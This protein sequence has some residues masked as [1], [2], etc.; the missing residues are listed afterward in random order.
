MTGARLSGEFHLVGP[1]SSPRWTRTAAVRPQLIPV[2]SPSLFCL[3]QD[4]FP[5]R[6]HDIVLS[7]GPA[8][9]YLTMR[10]LEQA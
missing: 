5:L 9:S 6:F 7:F 1:F 10:L 4:N 8:H 3:R 2:P